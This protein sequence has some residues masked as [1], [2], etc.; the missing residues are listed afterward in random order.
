MKCDQCLAV[1]ES[2][3]DRLPPGWKRHKDEVWCSECWKG[4]YVL[5][6]IT[7]PVAGPIDGEWND[8]RSTLNECWSQSTGIMNWAVT[9]LA[10]SDHPREHCDTKIAP[11]PRVYLY[12]GARRVEPDCNP[13]SVVAILHAV[14]GKYRKFRLATIWNRTQAHPV[15]RYPQP[16]PVHNNGWSC[17]HGPNKEPCVSVRLGNRR[18]LLRLRS[19][20][21]FRR[22][23]A[24]WK[25]IMSGQAVQGELAIIGQWVEASAN[26]PGVESREPGGGP[27][28]QLRVMAK[29]V[30]WMPKK[31]QTG[32]NGTLYVTTG[33]HPFLS[34]QVRDD[35]DNIRHLY[36]SHVIR[37]EEQHRKRLQC[38]AD[39]LKHEKRWPANVRRNMLAA[40]DRWVA[41]Y[42]DRLSSFTHEATAMLAN[43]AHRQG[44]SLV[45]LD[46]RCRN[47]CERFPWYELIS[48]L[49][50]KLETYGIALEV[51]EPKPVREQ[52]GDQINGN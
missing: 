10:R 11:A 24:G 48:K 16:Y 29:M 12:P 7:I 1:R 38:M 49:R 19:G 50:Y 26:R 46:T 2:K 40:Q 34:Y 14:E 37:W 6:A 35:E 8:L 44:V 20:P 33:R 23:I 41:K 9:E 30:A 39:D 28:K 32:L 3:N 5:R 36:A 43:F 4:Q 42:R 27:R 13:Q 17:A 45:H 51:V 18:W 21:Q 47:F 22:Q 15:Y 52:E 25:Q 31:L